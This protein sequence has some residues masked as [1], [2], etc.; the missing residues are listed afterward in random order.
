MG[1]VAC[2]PCRISGS[3]SDGY[4]ESSLVGHNAVIS[5]EIQ[6]TFR[7]HMSLEYSVSKNKPSKEPAWSRDQAEAR[8]RQCFPLKSQLTFKGL[9]GF[10]CQKTDSSKSPGLLKS[11]SYCAYLDNH[12]TDRAEVTYSCTCVTVYGNTSIAHFILWHD[13]LNLWRNFVSH[14]QF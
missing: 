4:E 7:R 12:S 13:T 1:A 10:T 6:K 8:G 11:I 14:S 5:V 9:H 2:S 3:H